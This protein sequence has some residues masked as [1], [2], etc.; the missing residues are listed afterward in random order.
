[1]IWKVVRA[2]AVD[3]DIAEWWA[4]FEVDS[5]V[6]APAA[7]GTGGDPESATEP[8][9]SAP[10]ATQIAECR[11]DGERVLVIHGHWPPLA[12]EEWRSL[13]ATARARF[14]GASAIVV[15]EV[16]PGRLRVDTSFCEVSHRAVAIAAG[17]VVAASWGWDESTRIRID[18]TNAR[19]DVEPR[20][21]GT[22][23][24]AAVVGSGPT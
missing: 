20:W 24:R 13:A 7:R 8:R 6:F 15:L 17:A 3:R 9:R 2:L 14:G 18:D 5:W 23:W 4:S 10:G 22:I 21:D 1:M 11:V 19:F 16:A 12:R